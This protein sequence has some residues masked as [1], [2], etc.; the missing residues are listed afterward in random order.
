MVQQLSILVNAC[1][2]RDIREHFVGSKTQAYHG[3][4]WAGRGGAGQDGT[5]AGRFT[6]ETTDPPAFQIIEEN[7]RGQL[8]GIPF[9]SDWGFTNYPGH[10]LHEKGL[11]SQ[12]V[13]GTLPNSQERRAAVDKPVINQ[14]LCCPIGLNCIS[15]VFASEESFRIFVSDALGGKKVR[16]ILGEPTSRRPVLPRLAPLYLPAVRRRA[17][18]RPWYFRLLDSTDI[19][20]VQNARGTIWVRHGRP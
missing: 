17:P 6:E 10:A 11:Q 3:R 15:F 7:C 13:I 14:M 5:H 19:I 1:H 18:T 2:P 20:S 16:Y 12:I 4:V 9:K 8:F